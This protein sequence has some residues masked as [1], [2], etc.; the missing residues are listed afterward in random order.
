[1]ARKDCTGIEGS[2]FGQTP[3]E[4]MKI[5]VAQVQ[6]EGMVCRKGHGRKRN[7]LLAV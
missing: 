5:A 7:R 1:M 2:I 3:A 4:R 6:Q